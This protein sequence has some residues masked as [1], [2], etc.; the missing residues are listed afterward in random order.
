MLTASIAHEVN[1]PLSGI[2]TNASTCLRMLSADPPNIEGARET[3]RRMLRD[4][5]RSSKVITRLRKLYSKKDLSLELM[6][7][8]DVAREV[9]SLSLGELQRNRVILRHELADDLPAVTA[10]RVQLQQVI[11]NLLRNASEAMSTV[12]DRPRE[13]LIRTERDG[14]HVR[15]S[16]KDTGLGL[17]AQ[18]TDKLFEAFYTTKYDGMGIGLSV[19]S[20]IVAAHQ[21]RLWAAPNDGY[22]ATFSFAIPCRADGGTIAPRADRVAGAI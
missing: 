4:G 7:L 9:T 5:N 1:Q 22:G 14:D 21:G 18:A 13:L 6:H 20:S 2:I 8:N 17:T 16:V 12:D 11:L 3:A 10:D 15:L 19:S